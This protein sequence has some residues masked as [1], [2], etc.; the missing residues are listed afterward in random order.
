MKKIPKCLCQNIH[1]ELF[2]R[3]IIEIDE[4]SDGLLPLC[5]IKFVLLVVASCGCSLFVVAGIAAWSVCLSL[6]GDKIE[7]FVSCSDRYS[8]RS[9]D[10][11]DDRNWDSG[12]S[13]SRANLN[14]PVFGISCIEIRLNICFTADSRVKKSLGC[15]YLFTLTKSFFVFAPKSTSY[16]LFISFRKVTSSSDLSSRL[17]SSSLGTDRDRNRNLFR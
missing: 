11:S 5:G 12:I 10:E 3:S 17:S 4:H 7:D 14:M 8:G 13:E 1:V 6:S 2:L 9:R 16:K 15:Y